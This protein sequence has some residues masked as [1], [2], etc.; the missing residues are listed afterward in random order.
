MSAWPKDK[1]RRIAEA[2]D[3]QIAV[4]REDGI[5]YGTP[6]WIWSVAVDGDLYVAR[7]LRS[8]VSLVPGRAAAKGRAGQRCRQGK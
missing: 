3:L 1:L 8:E 5:T 4:L 6:T 7:L 2:D